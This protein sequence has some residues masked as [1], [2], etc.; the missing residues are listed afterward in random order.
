M[1]LC[2]MGNSQR[3]EPAGCKP[4]GCGDIGKSPCWESRSARP[5]LQLQ[6]LEIMHQT[7]LKSVLLAFNAVSLYV[8]R[9]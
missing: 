4:A 3:G 5:N 8:G 9:G 6:T 1:C 2:P 7:E